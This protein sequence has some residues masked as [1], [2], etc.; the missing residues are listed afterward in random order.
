[1]VGNIR[2]SVSLLEHEHMLS[3]GS[4]L[5]VGG[6][7][8]TRLCK[9]PLYVYLLFVWPSYLGDAPSSALQ[10]EGGPSGFLEA[11]HNFNLFFLPHLF[12]TLD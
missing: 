3:S 4:G 9:R 12:V 8:P 2:I 6:Q 10:F 11:K 7:C 1:M 5:G